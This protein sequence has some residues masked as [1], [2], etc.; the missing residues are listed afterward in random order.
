MY[1]ATKIRM[2]IML[3]NTS[4]NTTRTLSL[5][6]GLGQNPDSGQING[7]RLVPPLVKRQRVHSMYL[8]IKR[9]QRIIYMFV[10]WLIKER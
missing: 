10:Q 5:N 4:S 1:N 3:A 9:L 8:S 2:I 7:L 6:R